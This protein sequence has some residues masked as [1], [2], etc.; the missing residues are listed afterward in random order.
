MDNIVIGL[1]RRPVDAKS[2]IVSG[3]SGTG[4]DGLVVEA[5]EDNVNVA[6]FPDGTIFYHVVGDICCESTLAT[7]HLVLRDCLRGR[8]RASLKSVIL[9]AG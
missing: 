9:N 3:D 2:I 5:R 7:L 4:A 8:E 1:S 6:R